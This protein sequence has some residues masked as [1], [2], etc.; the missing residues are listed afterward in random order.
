MFTHFANHFHE[1]SGMTWG[2]IGL[3]AIGRRVADL[4][5][6]FG[7]HVIY[8]ST[9]GNHTEDGY[10]RV[11]FDTL[12]KTSDIVSVHAPLTEQTE[13]LM[14]A[15]AFSKM[16]NSAIF[17]N[18]GRGPIVVEADLADAL[19][20]GEIAAAGLDVLSAEPMRE[21]NPLRCIKDSEKLVITPHIA[22]AAVET[23]KRLMDIILQQVKELFEVKQK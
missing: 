22:W 7:C 19:E 3:G 12:L 14:N 18:V 6:A 11:D 4:A 20:Q 17:I 23:R 8:Y 10:E 16:K 13:Q 5:K 9:S 2:I 15:A 21:D 1:L